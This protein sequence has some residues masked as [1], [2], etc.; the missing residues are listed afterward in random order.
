MRFGNIDLHNE[1]IKQV[2]STYTKQQKKRWWQ[3]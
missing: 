1:H 3:L 2:K